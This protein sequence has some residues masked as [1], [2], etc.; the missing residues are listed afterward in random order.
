[1]NEEQIDE[2]NKS[3]NEMYDNI[4]KS[5]ENFKSIVFKYAGRR[6]FLSWMSDLYSQIAKIS[7]HGDSYDRE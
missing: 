2:V 4:E 5:I 7:L 6:C 1:M 3:Y